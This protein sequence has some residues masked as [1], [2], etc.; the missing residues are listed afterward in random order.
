MDIKI[1]DIVGSILLIIIFVLYIVFSVK[2]D[3]VVPGLAIL[4]I[5]ITLL[6]IGHSYLYKKK[7]RNMKLLKFRF[8]FLGIPGYIGI[9][10]LSFQQIFDIDLS[11]NVNLLISVG[12]LLYLILIVIVELILKRKKYF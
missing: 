7:K 11:K 2:Y 1:E 8:S 6:L 4:W 5:G 9:I 10:F 3:S 12:T